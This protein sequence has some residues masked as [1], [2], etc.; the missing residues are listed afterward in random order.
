MHRALFVLLAIAA[1]LVGGCSEDSHP[2]GDPSSVASLNDSTDTAE[3]PRT[4]DEGTV[5]PEPEPEPADKYDQTWP[6]SYGKTTCA[7]WNSEMASTQQWTAAADMLAGTRNKG[8]G[9]TG[10][11]DDALVAEFQGGITTACVVDSHLITEVAV[12][13][14]LTDRK[15]FRP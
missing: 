9:G 10:L 8:D 2:P 7:E 15:R 11:P 12:G 1:L 14:Y 6:K 4:D 3:V 5:E 13:V